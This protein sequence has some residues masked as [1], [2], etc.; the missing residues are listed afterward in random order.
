MSAGAD[1]KLCWWD[2]EALDGAEIDM[3]K[4]TDFEMEPLKEYWLG[5]DV[6]VRTVLRS[7][8]NSEI[9]DQDDPLLWMESIPYWE[10]RGYVAIVMRNYWMY[11]RAAGAPSPSRRALAQGRWRQAAQVR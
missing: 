6:S 9:N 2:F 11:E 5:E 4:T 8:R 10:T 3:D 1:G 7:S